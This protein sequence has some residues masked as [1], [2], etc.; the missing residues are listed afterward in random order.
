MKI[1]YLFIATTLFLILGVVG[2]AAEPI[3]API[4][5][6][7]PPPPS[8]ATFTVTNLIIT[9]LIAQ[10]TETITI[11][12]E[13]KNTGGTPGNYL[14]IFKLNDEMKAQRKVYITVG[15][16]EYV[17]FQVRGGQGD[18]F[19]SIGEISAGY[20][21][22]PPTPPAPLPRYDPPPVLNYPSQPYPLY[23]DDLRRRQ[24]EY[25]AWQTQEALNRLQMEEIE[26]QK[27]RYQEEEER[28][29]VEE[30]MR[31]YLQ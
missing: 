21:V 5:A 26:R 15:G 9:P 22:L 6:P 4:P 16:K 10:P 17:S 18:Y 3:P 1:T 13:V 31:K 20:T 28:R 27:L 24:Q 30:M 7:A 19:A 11:T 29:R 2:C 8:P 23:S 12:A 14:A 25:R